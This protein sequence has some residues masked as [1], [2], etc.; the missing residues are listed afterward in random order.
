MQIKILP[1]NKFRRLKEFAQHFRI[2]EETVIAYDNCIYSNKT[3]P[4]DILEHEKYHLKRQ[5]EIGL[6][7]FIKKYLNDRQFRLKEEADAY[8][9]QLESIIDKGLK[10]AVKKDILNNL[11]S[12]LYGKVTMEEAKQLLK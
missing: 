2:T 9:I 7:T 8:K 6:N 10:Q 4:P 12:G 5:K 1:L 3:L 11:T